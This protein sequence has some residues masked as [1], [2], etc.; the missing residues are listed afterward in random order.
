MEE[1]MFG[2][3]ILILTCVVPTLLSLACAAGGPQAAPQP[4]SGSQPAPA[5]ARVK[6]VKAAMTGQPNGFIARMNTTQITIPGI[7]NLEQLVNASL[8]ELNAEGKL[9]P[10][11]A[12]SVPSLDNGLWKLFPDGRME[13]TWKIRQGARWHD[14]A[15]FT[16]ADL[17][18]ASKV[19]QDKDLPVL[20]PVGYGWVDKVDAPDPSTIVVTWNRPY[21]DA[22]TMFSHAYSAFSPPLPSHLL[23]E[24]HASD[25][26]KFMAMPY[27][28][29]EFVGS[30]PFRVREFIPGSR[31]LLQAND[32]YVLG[33]PK[34]DEIEMVFVLDPNALVTNILSGDV[35]LTIG[36]GFTTEQAI[37]LKDRWPQGRV[38]TFLKSWVAIHPQ[39]ISPTP[40]VV[41]D[42]RLRQALMYATDR[43]QLVET[44]QR[45][46]SQ[47]A[48]VYVSP[49]TQEYKEVADSVVKYPY[50]PRRTADLLSGM[51][52]IRGSDGAYR[53][54]SGTRLA[55]EVRSNGERITENAVVPVSDFWTRA[56][57]PTEPMVVPPQRII[58]REYV[59]TFPSF[60]MMRQP[61]RGTQISRIH[62]S[63]TPLPSNNFVGSNYARYSD[64]EFDGL[65]DQILSTIPWNQ[66]MD[67]YRQAV[68]HISEHLNLMGLFYDPD[69]AA[70]NNRL[71][72]L[73]LNDTEI[74]SVH[75]WD[76]T[77]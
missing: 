55:M 61:D 64:P 65:I 67:A 26:T 70:A 12:E 10:V 68:R 46:L 43:D 15:P 8:S 9:Q 63:L 23:A 51:G 41:T 3:R 31:I 35:D 73:G 69:F 30:G 72:N 74:W 57:I 59:A 75:L 34:I 37:E 5:P 4:A 14:G 20:K 77:Q 11:L 19:D 47:V 17:V 39:F 27:W 50:D 13:T 66:R 36:R 18:F 45:G 25:K 7:N 56:G 60:R 24:T 33:R 42:L 29:T 52:Y 32:Q 58:D 21:V 28:S 1:P 22:D 16:S 2:A 48:D 62:S 76:E 6:H 53:D 38:I 44:L 71:T 54:G 49:S 40:G